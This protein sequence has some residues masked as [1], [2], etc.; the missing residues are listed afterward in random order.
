M[1]KFTFFSRCARQHNKQRWKLDLPLIIPRFRL[2]AKA[3]R[4]RC[5]REARNTRRKRKNYFILSVGG[6]DV[7]RKKIKRRSFER[8]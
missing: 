7:V 1:P 2:S 4:R 6:F 8:E 3:T 5:R